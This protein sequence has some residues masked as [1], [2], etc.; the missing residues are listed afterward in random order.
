MDTVETIDMFTDINKQAIIE[1]YEYTANREKFADEMACIS[2]YQKQQW[3]IIYDELLSANAQITP[4]QTIK[5]TTRLLD[6][7]H[8]NYDYISNLI[9]EKHILE[10][11][12]QHSLKKNLQTHELL[13]SKDSQISELTMVQK[14]QQDAINAYIVSITNLKSELQLI[15]HN[16]DTLAEKFDAYKYRVETKQLHIL[17]YMQWFVILIAFIL[18]GFEKVI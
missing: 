14:T 11:C 6:N 4:K 15:I 1:V 17:P 9:N 10:E 5:S 16:F 2:P 13:E 18:Y 8:F 7:T 12:V 3:Y